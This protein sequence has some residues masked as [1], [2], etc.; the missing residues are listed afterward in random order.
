VNNSLYD[1]DLQNTGSG[2]FQIQYRAT[3]IVFENNSVF[4]GPQGLFIH[5]YVPGSRVTLNHNDYFST[6]STKAFEL[7]GSTYASFPDY[8]AATGQDEDSIF[9]NPEFDT[10]PTCVADGTTPSGGFSSATAS[11]CSKAADLDIRARSAAA[12]VGNNALGTPGLGYSKYERSQPFVGDLD[13]A[14]QPRV[15]SSGLINVG[16]YE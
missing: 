3:G 13:F 7:D 1:D 11:S 9:A 15:K 2:E 5:G 6:R 8:R 12:G 4:S 14:G 16:A 10:L